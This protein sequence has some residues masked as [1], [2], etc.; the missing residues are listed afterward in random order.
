MNQ[1]AD[2]ASKGGIAGI[3]VYLLNKIDPALGAMSVPLVTGLLAYVST[4]VKDPT[5]ASFFGSKQIEG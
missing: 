5:L 2:Q 1:I 4:K 3:V